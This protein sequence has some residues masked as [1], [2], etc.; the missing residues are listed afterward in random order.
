M[1]EGRGRLICFAARLNVSSKSG[2][3][4]LKVSS[5]SGKST[6]DEDCC[7]GTLAPHIICG[8]PMEPIGQHAV[9]QWNPLDNRRLGEELA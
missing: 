8:C 6:V 9:V 7:G 3:S 2:K 4:R 5:K 1:L